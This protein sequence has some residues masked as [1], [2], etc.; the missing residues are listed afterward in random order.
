MDAWIGLLQKSKRKE[1]QMGH[2]MTLLGS[3]IGSFLG[4]G[5]V[6]FIMW[7]R[8]QRQQIKLYANAAYGKF[9]EP[10]S[11]GYYGGRVETFKTSRDVEGD[12]IAGGSPPFTRRG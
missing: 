1:E 6:T 4:T 8:W 9:A 11:F 2:L 12:I 5:V 3:L 7:R 10:A